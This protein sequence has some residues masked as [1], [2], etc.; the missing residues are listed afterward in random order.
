ML[1]LTSTLRPNHA[2]WWSMCSWSSPVSSHTLLSRSILTCTFWGVQENQTIVPYMVDPDA[3]QSVAIWADNP[4]NGLDYVI[5]VVSS[6]SQAPSKW[7][8]A[9]LSCAES[10]TMSRVKSCVTSS[11][12]ETNWPET[13]TANAPTLSVYDRGASPQHTA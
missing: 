3:A 1:R 4:A 11:R 9:P 7:I 8:P 13:R 2:P 10:C 5:P 6:S 12:I